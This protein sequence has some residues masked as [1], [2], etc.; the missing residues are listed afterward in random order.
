MGVV[1]VVSRSGIM[2]LMLLG[3][4]LLSRTRRAGRQVRLGRP[5]GDGS[6]Y[7][8]RRT[9]PWKPYLILYISV[10][11]LTIHGFNEQCQWSISAIH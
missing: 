3:A 7:S 9:A 10:A 11:C 5:L 1:A 6:G 4:D 8:N 2:A